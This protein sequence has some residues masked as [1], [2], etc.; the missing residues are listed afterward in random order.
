[1]QAAQPKQ[2]YQ[3]AQKPHID[4]VLTELCASTPEGETLTLSEL[5]NACQ[6]TRN[7]IWQIEQRALRKAR[8][9][10][11]SKNINFTDLLKA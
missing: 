1:M 7:N 8:F 11:A 9:I 10:L 5:A 2:K 4:H 3:P 6:C